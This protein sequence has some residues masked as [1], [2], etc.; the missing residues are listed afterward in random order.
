MTAPATTAPVTA[1][2]ASTSTTTLAPA[3]TAAL[4]TTAPTTIATTVP[5]PS[6]TVAARAV[7]PVLSAPV[8]TPPTAPATIGGVFAV[9]NGHRVAQ[10][11]APLEYQADLAQCAQAQSEWMATHHE[12]VHS[13]LSCPL[14]VGIAQRWPCCVGENLFY[15]TTTKFSAA[16]V[17]QLWMDS[18][19]HR[20]QMLDPRYRVGGVGLATS[21]DGW[22]W[23]T[24]HFGG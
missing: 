21:A 11:L 13:D 5:A 12:M 6:P 16:F 23:I 10:G 8:A 1:P 14:G 2:P 4:A 9:V 17:G 24:I 22:M 7:A 15:G 20:A 18:P 19:T 3:T